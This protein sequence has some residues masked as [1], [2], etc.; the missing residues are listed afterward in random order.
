MTN[1]LHQLRATVER[2]KQECDTVI[3]QVDALSR[4]A[5][6]G[7]APIQEGEMLRIAQHAIDLYASRSP[8]PNQV[9]VTQAAEMLGLSR[10][11]VSKMVKF[12][13][14][15]LNRCGMIPIEQVDAALRSA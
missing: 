13:T 9:T 2:I 4:E 8:R 1:P 15:K 3:R 10:H 7:N 5:T 6:M 11:T 12:G 14:L